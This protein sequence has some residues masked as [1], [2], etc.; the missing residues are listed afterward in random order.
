MNKIAS[1]LLLAFLFIWA[2]CGNKYHLKLES[3]K[4]IQIHKPLKISVKERSGNPIDSIQYFINGQSIENNESI[5]IQ[6]FNLGKQSL[7]ATIYYEGKHKKLNNTI[8]F[9]NDAPPTVY[10]YEIINEYP[11][12]AN[13][14]T[15]GFAYYQGYFYE[16]TGQYGSSSLRKTEIATG[17][18]LKKLNRT[19]TKYN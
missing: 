1:V 11:H 19:L 14:F 4:S 17:K 8:Y 10:T 13:A 2:G 6:G 3:P 7:S 9:L 18:I 15:Q 16:S 12:D 5:D